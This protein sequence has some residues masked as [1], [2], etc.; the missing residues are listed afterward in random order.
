MYANITYRRV[1]VILTY[2]HCIS[3]YCFWYSPITINVAWYYIVTY[4][5][6]LA[7]NCNLYILLFML[8]LYLAAC[9]SP[10]AASTVSKCS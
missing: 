9:H 1:K 4:P 2:I 7:Y 5:V 8:A 10:E 6:T 3:L